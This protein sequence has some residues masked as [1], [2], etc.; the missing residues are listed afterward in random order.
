M[1]M[2]YIALI[3]LSWWDPW[4]CH[5]RT[6]I[7]TIKIPPCWLPKI[8]CLLASLWGYNLLPTGQLIFD[9]LREVIQHPSE[10]PADFLGHLTE[11]LTCYTKLD[12]SSR[13]GMLILN[14][15]FI[16]QS[17]P[18]IRKKLKQAKDALN[19]PKEIL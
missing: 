19:P 6:H 15:H 5:V 9:K 10:N 1:L 18:D 3:S 11:T 2:M 4:Q 14:S 13:A 7:G 8:I 17:S 16:S 12:P